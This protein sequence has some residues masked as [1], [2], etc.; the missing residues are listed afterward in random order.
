MMIK[1]KAMT[2]LGLLMMVSLVIVSTTVQAEEYMDLWPNQR[3]KH[4]VTMDE[5]AATYKS[6]GN[7]YVNH[8]YASGGEYP[9]E[10]PA[11]F[12]SEV[13]LDLYPVDVKQVADIVNEST[14]ITGQ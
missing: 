5:Q 9:I 4:Q 11:D 10:A 14:N 7:D 6:R 8:I 3:A 13:G 2:I 1:L 12:Q